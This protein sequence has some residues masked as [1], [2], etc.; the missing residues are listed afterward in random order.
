MTVPYYG[1]IAVMIEYYYRNLRNKTFSQP[2]KF[3]SGCWISVVNPT[4]AELDDLAND[5]DINRGHLD[6][7]TDE[8]EMPRLEREDKTVYFFTRTPYITKG[9]ETHTTALLVI[10][11]DNFI[12]TISQQPVPNMETILASSDFHTTQRTQLFIYVLN[13]VVR[14]F[15]QLLTLISKQVKA[16]RSRLRVQA[17]RNQ[18][19]IKFV[20]I[21]DEI[22]EFLSVLQPTNVILRRVLLGKHIKLY[23]EDKELVEDLLLSNEQSVEECRSTLKTVVN[24]REAHSTIMTNNLNRVMKVLTVATLVLAVPTLITGIYGM[25]VEL[26]FQHEDHAFIW[27]SLFSTGLA[28]L[29]VMYFLA[30]RW[31]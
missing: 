21:E 3:K 24:I 29:I 15:N 6:D 4:A 27:I 8:D 30:K 11:G 14:E 25:N 19:F 10:I 22:N 13:N 12:A 28:V 5:L 9:G 31:I 20:E 7:A 17:V 16:V 23:R 2:E 1:I 26:P 18:D